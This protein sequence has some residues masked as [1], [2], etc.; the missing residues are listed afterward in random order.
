MSFDR[1]VALLQ[2]ASAEVLV[3]Y[4]P[5]HLTGPLP[6]PIQ[7]GKTDADRLETLVLAGLSAHYPDAAGAGSEKCGIAGISFGMKRGDVTVITGRVGTGKT[8]HLRALLGLVPREAGEIRW[9]GVMIEE[10]SS[11]F[12]PPRTAY[13]AQVPALFSESL[14]DNI[15]MCLQEDEAAIQ[16]ALHLTVVEQDLGEMEQGLDTSLG[17]RGAR[18]SG[19]QRQRTAAARMFVRDPEL[20]VIDDLGSALDVETERTLWER[21]FGQRDATCLVVS[22]RR[23]VLQRADQIIVLV[24]GKVEAMGTP[25][26]L[27]DESEE[28]RRLWK[29]EV[30]ADRSIGVAS[31]GPPK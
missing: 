12:V 2:G 24:D 13:V 31:A 29:G 9:N 18:L 25:V 7:P 14:R 16:A 3:K 17:A 27:L 11:C 19:G 21:V 15:L 26:R 4:H 22:N 1:L 10:P 30:E 28:F 20:L 5:V 6:E 23:S 8:T